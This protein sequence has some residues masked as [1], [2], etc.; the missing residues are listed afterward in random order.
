MTGN[1][2]QRKVKPLPSNWF[3]AIAAFRKGRSSRTYFGKDFVETYA[4]LKEV[5]ADRF[6]AEPTLRDFS[7]GTCGRCEHNAA[8]LR[9]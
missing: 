4:T 5:E 3:E 1:G 6:Y 2:Y 9:L 7:S 8:G